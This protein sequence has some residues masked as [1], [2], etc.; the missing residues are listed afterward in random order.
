MNSGKYLFSQL[1]EF[2]ADVNFPF[3]GQPEIRLQYSVY[4]VFRRMLQ[5]LIDF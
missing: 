2:F 3:L 5:L 1:I 4:L